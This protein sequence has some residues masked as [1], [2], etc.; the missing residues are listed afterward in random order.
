MYGVEAEGRRAGATG[1][2]VGERKLGAVGVRISEGVSTHGLALNVAR[3][4]SGTGSPFS[5]VVPCG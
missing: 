1:V 3:H 4:L 2:W 5:F